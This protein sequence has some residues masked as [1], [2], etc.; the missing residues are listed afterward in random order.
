VDPGLA[1]A[2]FALL[3]I[4]GYGRWTLV[5]TCTVRTKPTEPLLRRLHRVATD[6]AWPLAAAEVAIVECAA[7]SK[8]FGRAGAVQINGLMLATGAILATLCTDFGPDLI[9]TV[10]P[11][12][13]WPRDGRKMRP[14]SDV[15][16]R[17]R[18]VCPALDDAS[19]HAVTAAAIGDWYS[20]NTGLRR[21]TN[22]AR[23]TA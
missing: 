20:R 3:D 5:N 17:M 1:A 8:P 19:E 14:E 12:Q 2:G 7:G 4:T 23:R 22:A 21:L 9:D 11:Q 10:S 16:G 15:I 18:T 13:W 6:T